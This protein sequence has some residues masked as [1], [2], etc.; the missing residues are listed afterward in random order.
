MG[1]SDTH[2]RRGDDPNAGLL[3]RVA[4][5]DENALAEL[6]DSQSR[7]V[8]SLVFTLLGNADDAE[9]VTQE[10]F[11]RVWEKAHT[12][13]PRRGSGQA[14]IVTMARRLA[15]DRTRSKQHKARERS[16]SL[17]VVAESSARGAEEAVVGSAEAAEVRSA[18]MKLD[19]PHREVI[20]LAYFGGM[21]HSMIAAHLD[22]PLGT[23]KSRLRDAVGQL[24]KTLN[25]KT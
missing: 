2:S 16:V 25:V 12:F 18:I 9:E 4:N 15:I 1:N 22:T 6:Y 21:S 5:K 20:E 24:R 17:D 19:P 14:W 11:V 10:V 23:V 8:Y 13:D 7:L 3:T